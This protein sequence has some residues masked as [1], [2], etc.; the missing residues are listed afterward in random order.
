MIVE[1]VQ[2]I[3]QLVVF[4]CTLETHCLGLPYSDVSLSPCHWKH[5]NS[6]ICDE[7]SWFPSNMML[8]FGVHQNRESCFSES[9]FRCFFF[10]FT[11]SMCVFMCLHWGEDWVLPHHHKAQIEG[12]LQWCS[13]IY[14]TNRRKN[15]TATLH[16]SGLYGSVTILWSWSSTR[17]TIGFLITTLIKALLHQLLSLPGKPALGR[18]LVVSNFFH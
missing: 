15:I 7:Q 4:N 16:R 6:M 14:T 2:H 12:V 9:V 11:N 18:D 8:R 13:P 10:F 3:G 1:S 5:P 17:V